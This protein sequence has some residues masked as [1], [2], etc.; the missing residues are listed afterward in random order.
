MVVYHDFITVFGSDFM[1]KIEAAF[2]NLHET[3]PNVTEE[4]LLAHL[5]TNH[6]DV[7]GAVAHFTTPQHAQPADV[8]PQ[9][10]Q[11]RASLHDTDVMGNLSSTDGLSGFPVVDLEDELIRLADV[12]DVKPRSDTIPVDD[13][14]PKKVAKPSPKSTKAKKRSTSTGRGWAKGTGYGG[15]RHGQGS[16]WKPEDYVREQEQKDNEVWIFAEFQNSL[17]D[18]FCS[19]RRA[20]CR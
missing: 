13:Q 2:T 10:S 17:I 18:R 16:K 8:V 1:A 19:S 20:C 11:G 6:F 15:G 3:L 12:T 5:K 9:A 4:M 7:D 14:P